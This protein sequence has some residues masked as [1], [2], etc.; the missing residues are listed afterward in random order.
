MPPML[1]Q[2]ENGP[3]GDGTHGFFTDGGGKPGGDSEIKKKNEK[4]QVNFYW[5]S[6]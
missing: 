2:I 1:W 4:I 3:Q 6:L 5:K